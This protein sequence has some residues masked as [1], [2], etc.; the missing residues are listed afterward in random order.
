M[1]RNLLL[2]ALSFLFFFSNVVFSQDAADSVALVQEHHLDSLRLVRADSLKKINIA[3]I[4]HL[5]E[6][7]SKFPKKRPTIGLALAGGGAKGF[8]HAGMLQ[9][10][11][12]LNI[13]I[14]YIVG[15]SMGGL[16]AALYSVGYSGKDLEEY[17]VKLDW[18]AMLNDTPERDQLPFIE[19]KKDGMYQLSIGLKG[20]KPTAPSGVI[21]G[22]NAQMEFLRM[23]A[24]YED[25]NNFDNLPIPFRCVAVDLVTGKEVVLKSGSL[26]KAMRATMSIPSAFSPVDWD[27]YLLVDG[28]VLNNFPVDVVKE[29]GPDIV[30]GLNLTTGRVEKKD[31][32]DMFSILNRTTDIPMSNRLKENIKLSDIY[33]SQ[34][35]NGF[36]TNDFSSEKIKG[37]I[38]RGKNAGKRY[39]DVFVALKEGL[40]NYKEYREWA[41]S[42]K[43]KKYN[44][45]IKK[46]ENFVINPAIIGKVTLIGNKKFESSFILNYLQIEEGQVFTVKSVQKKINELYALNYFES[47]S[48]ETERIDSNKIDLQIKVKEKLVNRVVAGFKYDDNFKLVGLFGIETNS[49]LIQGAQLEA[50]LRFGGVTQFDI[51]VLYPSRSMDIP[52]YPFLKVGYRDLPINFYI[53]GRKYF[54]FRNRGW[55]F[56][57]GFNFSLS[58]FWNFEASILFEK[59]DVVADIASSDVEKIIENMH[60]EASILQGRLKLLFD[61]LDDVIIPNSGFYF[62]ANLEFS[63]KDLSSDLQYLKFSGLAEYFIQLS[64]KNDIILAGV[65]AYAGKGTPFYKWFYLGGPKTFVGIDYFQANGTEFAIGQASYRYEFIDGIYVKGITNLMFNYNMASFDSPMRGKPIFGSAISLIMKTMFGRAELMFARG[66]ANMYAPGRKSNHIYFTFGYRLL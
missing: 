45:I 8:A 44:K 63:R 33:V 1:K 60:P 5:K 50:Y 55:E 62:R 47:I 58:K 10:I 7:F 32:G 3:T 21:Y 20:Y 9:L 22:H 14:D 35:L 41:D 24:P 17:G 25:V 4:N 29:M 18:G 2:F 59:M 16:V 23:T 38:K 37:I 26:A 48:Y 56:S 57:G 42:G 11:D 52:V 61:S 40:E 39:L 51:T 28:L 53:D 36:S 66:D 12:S 43:I 64:K 30:I 49:A 46:R 19:K 13:P 15:N 65:Y 34:D 54:S 31:L 6:I 27:N